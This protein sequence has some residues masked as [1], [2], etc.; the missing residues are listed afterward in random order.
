MC[1]HKFVKIVTS[2]VPCKKFSV[3]QFFVLVRMQFHNHVDT[4]S[5]TFRKG[6]AMCI[7][8]QILNVAS[9]QE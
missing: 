3:E 5:E 7:R 9:A 4:T 2:S 1:L 8:Y 6:Y